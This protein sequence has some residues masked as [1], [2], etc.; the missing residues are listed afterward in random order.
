VL[1]CLIGGVLGIA[2]ALGIGE[3][4]E[5]V[6][7]SFGMT[8]SMS[9]IVA[10]FGVSSVIGVVFGYLPARNAARLDPVEALARP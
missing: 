4:I 10:A 5:R 2:L 7:G 9:S 8:Y 6:S 1:V 3:L